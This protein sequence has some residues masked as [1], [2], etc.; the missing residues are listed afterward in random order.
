MAVENKEITLGELFDKVKDLVDEHGREPRVI[1][2]GYIYE[3]IGFRTTNR[4]RN[5][6]ESAHNDVRVII[7]PCYGD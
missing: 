2:D 7:E 1:V 6:A 3:R 4:G 5:R